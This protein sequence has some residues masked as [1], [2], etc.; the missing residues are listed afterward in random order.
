MR[1]PETPPGPNGGS[2]PLV[3]VAHV[4]DRRDI[5]VSDDRRACIRKDGSLR[6]V[7][8]QRFRTRIMTL[9]EFCSHCDTLR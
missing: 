3:M 1:A 4:S 8:E 6:N 7:L 5:L 2:G 9:D